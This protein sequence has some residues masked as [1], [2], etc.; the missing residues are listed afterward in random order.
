MSSTYSCWPVDAFTAYTL[1]S[2]A[3]KYTTPSNPIAG[4]ERTAPAV[5][6]DQI[7]TPVVLLMQS[8]TLSSVPTYRVL[9]RP[10]EQTRDRKRDGR[11]GRVEDD[12]CST[13]A[14]AYPEWGC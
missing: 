1:L 4:T 12:K 2:C 3:P 7:V 9:S 8:R 13:Q 6:A 11:F 10:A 14:C 5:L